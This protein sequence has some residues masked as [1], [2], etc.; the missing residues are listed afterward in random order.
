MERE[1][2]GPVWVPVVLRSGWVLPFF[3]F[4]ISLLLDSVRELIPLLASAGS[5]WVSVTGSTS[6]D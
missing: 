4:V 1:G 5:G 2:S 6:P 3:S